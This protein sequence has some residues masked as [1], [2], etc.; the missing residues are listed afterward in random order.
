MSSAEIKEELNGPD[1]YKPDTSAIVAALALLAA[2][3]GSYLFVFEN[4][5][6]H[7]APGN[8]F[9][10]IFHAWMTP[11]YQHGFFV[12][13][14][15]GFLLW[16]RRDMM[17][18]IPSQGSMW[19]L[20]LFAVWAFLRFAGE[21]FKFAY[22]HH[23]SIVFGIAAIVLFAGGWQAL[24]WSWPALVFMFFAIPLP[25]VLTNLLSQP[26]QAIGCRCSVYL[27]QTLGI[28]CVRMEN[29]IQLS[30][31]PNPLNVAEACSGIRMLMLFFAL[32]L[33]WA[34]LM[35]N[36]EP[37]DKLQEIF[38]PIP[39]LGPLFAMICA[40]WERWLIVLSSI[41]IAVAANV[42]RL[43]LIAVFTKLVLTWPN[44][45]LSAELLK[46]W[47]NNVTETWAHD[48]P[49]YL[50]MPIGMILLSIEWI[51]ISKLFMEV[52]AERTASIRGTQG[53][54]PMAP[55]PRKG[56]QA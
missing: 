22:P 35:K 52:P 4:Y 29:S 13:P 10:Y 9:S 54:L 28:P 25:G 37:S 56:K 33:G 20:A 55:S 34:F 50:M 38:S 46:N 2:F 40:N 26:L 3:V 44:Y 18:S 41:P 32:C 11:D 30:D 42:L 47:P 39:V 17:T 19:G 12:L 53:L 6:F 36:R 51:L 43:T 31:M 48:L 45:L 49:G 14:F 27:I 21:Y 15:C 24:R 5:F 7:Y 8:S 16:H 23:I 1:G